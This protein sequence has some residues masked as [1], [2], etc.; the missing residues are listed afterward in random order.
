MGYEVRRYGSIWNENG[1]MKY[2][3]MGYESMKYGGMGVYGM[4]MGV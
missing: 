3:S 1:G 4:R 2:G